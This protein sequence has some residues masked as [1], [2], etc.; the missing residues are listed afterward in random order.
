MRVLSP[1]GLVSINKT[2]FSDYWYPYTNET[3]TMYS[4]ETLTINTQ[5]AAGMV[6]CTWQNSPNAAARELHC[7]GD[8][9]PYAPPTTQDIFGC[10][11]GPFAIFET[12]NDVHRAV[13][14]RLCAAYNRGTFLGQ[15]R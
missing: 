3:A 2:A 11:T 5:A 13:V 4:K 10:N 15:W 14:P 7:E 8:N 6:N 9:R 12:D 1:A